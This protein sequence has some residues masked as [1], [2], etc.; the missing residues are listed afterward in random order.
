[1]PRTRSQG[2]TS[3]K[4]STVKNKYWNSQ[5]NFHHTTSTNVCDQLHSQHEEEAIEQPNSLPEKDKFKCLGCHTT[6]D[7]ESEFIAHSNSSKKCLGKN[8]IFTCYNCYKSFSTRHNLDKHLQHANYIQCNSKHYNN[9]YLNAHG[10]TLFMQIEVNALT[11]PEHAANLIHVRQPDSFPHMSDYA[12]S[13][14]N[15]HS[16]NTNLASLANYIEGGNELSSESSVHSAGFAVIDEEIIN[17]LPDT[18]MVERKRKIDEIRS[19]TCYEQDYIAGLELE[20][21]LHRSGAPLGL[22]NSVMSW[23]RRNHDNI[24]IR[25]EIFT[26]Q[27]LYDV[28]LI[29]NNDWIVLYKFRNSYNF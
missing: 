17:A 20:D 1:M 23:A 5:H 19:M 6:F 18:S 25:S 9:E 16:T 15:K 4:K 28:S 21:I 24:P 22:F 3:K 7:T 10:S 27:K 2:S 26:R 8:Q 29:L 12:R 14:I 13:N 11:N